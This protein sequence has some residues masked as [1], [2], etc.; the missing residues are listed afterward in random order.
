MFRRIAWCAVLCCASLLMTACAP[1]D[2][3]GDE[4]QAGRP[5]SPAKSPALAPA[6]SWN[7]IRVGMSHTEVLELLGAPVEV[8]VSRVTTRWYY[9][10]RATDGPHVVLT[11]S[12]MTVERFRRPT[13]D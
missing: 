5:S 7:Q 2:K 1:A 12:R 10:D 4:V 13:S 3:R 9:S 6:A 8:K 11:T